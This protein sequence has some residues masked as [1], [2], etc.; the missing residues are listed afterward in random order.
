MSTVFVGTGTGISDDG[1]WRLAVGSPAIQAGFGSTP[2]KPID[3]GMYGANTPYVV[4]GLPTV[5]S[6]YFF[7]N[8]AIGSNSVPINVSIKVK[9]NN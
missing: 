5:P 4:S 3:A 1:Q 8:T 9:S 7:E 2:A 6:I